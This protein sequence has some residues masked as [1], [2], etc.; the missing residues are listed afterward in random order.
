M[1]LFL[2]Y[3]KGDPFFFVQDYIAFP[4]L[5]T[6]DELRGLVPTFIVTTNID[7][8]QYESLSA[9]FGH[10]S[11]VIVS[12]MSD[13]DAYRKLIEAG[14]YAELHLINGTCHTCHEHGLPFFR[15]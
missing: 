12:V 1:F 4:F 8:C 13:I 3:Y 10:S 6:V 2:A 5:A 9:W 14:V 7:P 11:L 15:L